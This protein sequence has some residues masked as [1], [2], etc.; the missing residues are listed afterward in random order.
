[1]F[2][3]IFLVTA[4]IGLVFVGSSFSNPLYMYRSGICSDSGSEMVYNSRTGVWTGSA[5]V[6]AV[7]SV[8]YSTTASATVPGTDGTA[9][10]STMSE[11]WQSKGTSFNGIDYPAQL[12][13][14]VSITI[15]SAS[16]WAW[17]N[18]QLSQN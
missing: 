6:H 16:G 15:T 3:K 9:S 8:G 4:L 11:A 2:K 17:A 7:G 13:M 14:Y 10:V 5:S 12:Y 1:M 18:A